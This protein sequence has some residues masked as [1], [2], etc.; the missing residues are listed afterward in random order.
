VSRALTIAYIFDN[1]LLA[2]VTLG[3]CDIGDTLSSKAHQL[4]VKGRPQGRL[5]RPLIDWLFSGMEPNHCYQ[6]YKTFLQITGAT[7]NPR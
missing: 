4:D 7:K 1:L 5:F 6:A 3:N 2:L